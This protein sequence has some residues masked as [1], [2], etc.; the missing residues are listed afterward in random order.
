MYDSENRLSLS[1][2]EVEAHLPQ[3]LQ[4]TSTLLETHG[5]KR[6]RLHDDALHH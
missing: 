5:V 4:M 1:E 3:K 6:C 2:L